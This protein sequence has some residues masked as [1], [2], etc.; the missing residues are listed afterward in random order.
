MGTGKERQIDS[1][2][3]SWHGEGE[4][5]RDGAEGKRKSRIEVAMRGKRGKGGKKRQLGMER[6]VADELWE[7]TRGLKVRSNMK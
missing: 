4:G 7:K 1:G 2:T 6:K 3:M 5:R